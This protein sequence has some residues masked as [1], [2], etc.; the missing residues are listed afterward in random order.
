MEQRV[1]GWVGWV[2][3]GAFALLSVGLFNLITG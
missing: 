2:W 3:F 1:T